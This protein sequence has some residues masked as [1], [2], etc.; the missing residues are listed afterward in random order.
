MN[1]M[2]TT[3]DTDRLPVTNNRDSV[4]PTT[5]V[6]S[7]LICLEKRRGSLFYF[8]ED[9]VLVCAGSIPGQMSPFWRTEFSPSPVTPWDAT[10]LRGDLIIEAVRV[11]LWDH[12]FGTGVSVK[13]ILGMR[14]EGG[15]S[16][17]V[18]SN[19]TLVK[20]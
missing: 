1:T 13:P 5:V 14:F 10:G 18:V 15:V 12:S 2:G 6:I 16:N 4:E 17:V 7:S 3:L 9:S 20:S 11:Y 19:S 8:G